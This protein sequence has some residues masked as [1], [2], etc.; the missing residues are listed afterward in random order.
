MSLCSVS[1]F[2][3]SFCLLYFK[4]NTFCD[5]VFSLLS[6][7]LLNFLLHFVVFALECHVHLKA[8]G[9]VGICSS[10]LSVFLCSVSV[11]RFSTCA[12]CTLC[13]HFAP[14]LLAEQGPCWTLSWGG[15]D[16]AKY[17]A[18]SWI[19]GMEEGGL[20]ARFTDSHV[21][22]QGSGSRWLAGL[23]IFCDILSLNLQNAILLCWEG[24]V[25]VFS[26]SA[27]DDL[28][29]FCLLYKQMWCSLVQLTAGS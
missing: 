25:V 10:G 2:V 13:F 6:I 8:V 16:C 19:T 14:G 17:W 3:F 29:L 9:W 23:L 26:S 28:S 18:P 24:G 4:L 1:V 7:S 15:H 11:C 22:H 21:T 27:L 12:A 20:A 5:T